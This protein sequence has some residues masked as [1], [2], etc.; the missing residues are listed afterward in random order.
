MAKLTKAQREWKP[1][2]PK[3]LRSTKMMFASVVL[4]LEAFVA[5]FLGLGLFGLKDKNP[6]YLIAA[7]VL[8]FLLIMAC[9]F[10]RKPWGVAVG[11]VLQ[12]LLIAGGFWEPSMF[13]VGVLFAAAWWYAL[14]GGARIDRDNA[15]RA[16]AQAEWDIAHPEEAAPGA[17]AQ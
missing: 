8:A 16:K 1:N 12:G 3:K 17:G 9:A 6:A 4:V 13:V 10:L 2:T 11:W 14:F 15:A 7:V 5:I